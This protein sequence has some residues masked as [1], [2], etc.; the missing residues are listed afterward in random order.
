MSSPI[1]QS[2]N[3]LGVGEKEIVPTEREIAVFK[4]LIGDPLFNVSD[5]KFPS[6]MV[7]TVARYGLPVPIGNVVGYSRTVPQV[8]TPVLT[9]ETTTSDSFTDLAT[10]GPEI[11]G[12]SA[13]KYLLIYSAIVKNDTAGDGATISVSL[14]GAAASAD[15]QALA[16][17]GTALTSV[18][19][20]T[21]ATLSASGANTVT[22][23][24]ARVT[25]GTASF[26]YRRLL[27]LRAGNL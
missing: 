12:M 3:T 1:P 4:K 27:A 20:W 13:G 8:A 14:N 9:Q 5:T 18:V 17:S 22:M 6:W 24:Y 25:A 2:S 16:Q 7:D 15:D 23:K 10:V 11:T 21:L 19:G 26:S